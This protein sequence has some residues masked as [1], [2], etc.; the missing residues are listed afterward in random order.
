MLVQEAD[1]LFGE[2]VKKTERKEGALRVETREYA[3]PE[4]RT[5]AEFVEGV[6]IRYSISS[7]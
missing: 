5:T 7:N 6:L 1:A 4:G 3:P 2:P